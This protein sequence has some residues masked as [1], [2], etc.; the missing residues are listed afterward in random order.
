MIIS[1]CNFLTDVWIYAAKLMEENVRNKILTIF[2]N[3]Y[4]PFKEI[5]SLSNHGIVTNIILLE[6]ITYFFGILGVLVIQTQKI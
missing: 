1:Y 2:F 3:I 6:I 5:D 4:S